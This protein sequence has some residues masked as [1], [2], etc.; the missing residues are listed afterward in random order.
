VAG[1][2]RLRR[3]GAG[4]RLS[5]ASEVELRGTLGACLRLPATVVLRLVQRRILLGIRANAE[6]GR[7]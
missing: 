6:H 5:L 7:R 2:Y 3:A 4:T 1:A